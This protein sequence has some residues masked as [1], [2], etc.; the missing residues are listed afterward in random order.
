MK[1]LAVKIK[2]LGDVALLVPQMRILKQ[3]FKNC[4]IHALVPD[5]ATPLLVNVPWVD[6]VWGI[7]RKKGLSANF[8]LFLA[9]KK[10][11]YDLSVD[12]VGNDRGAVASFFAHAP[13][14]L[15]FI[16][17]KGFFARKYCYTHR[18]SEPSKNTHEIDRAIHLLS[19]LKIPLS[20]ENIEPELYSDPA[21]K[22]YAL[23]SLPKKTILC[24]LS[25]SSPAKEW[26]VANWIELV[27][28]CDPPTQARFVFVAGKEERALSLLKQ[29]KS[30]LPFVRV[31]EPIPNIPQLMALIEAASC[32]ISGDTFV[33]HAAAGLKKRG[34][35]LF[36][37]TKK[38]AWHPKGYMTVLEAQQCHCSD[39][40]SP[41]KYFSAHCLSKISPKNVKDK[42]YQLL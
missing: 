14:R 29:L 33:A 1:I 11:N 22:P 8:S 31:I 6:K 36:G 5:Y 24:N 10:E 13:L 21:L 38:E 19:R 12:F 39:Y 42:L 34:I 25:T 27:K 26:P 23:A 15:G 35:A 7:Q 9:L 41:C 32:V 4:Q 37:P 18:Q 20:C 30:A 40:S 17:E 3:S 28:L 16:W 2:F